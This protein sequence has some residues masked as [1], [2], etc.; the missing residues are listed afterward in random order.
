MSRP[1]SDGC[2]VAVLD[3]LPQPGP[4]LGRIVAVAVLDVLGLGG[5]CLVLDRLPEPAGIVTLTQM[6][7]PRLVVD[8]IAQLQEQLQVLCS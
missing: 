5:Q 4:A 3:R 7:Q 2:G 6:M 1:A 8:A